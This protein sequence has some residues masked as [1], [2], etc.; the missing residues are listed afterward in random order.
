ME[1]SKIAIQNG[2]LSLSAE[3]SEAL[4]RDALQF[5]EKFLG[6]SAPSTASTPIKQPD[7][8]DI[9]VQKPSD[10]AN[11][12]SK[13]ENVFDT[14]DDKLKII[15]HVPGKTK[16]EQSRNVALVVL[17]GQLLLGVEQ[18]PS[19]TIRQ[20][21]VDQGCYDST[22]FAQYLKGLKS[23]VVM[24]TKTGGGYDVKLTAPGRKDAKELIE[25]LNGEG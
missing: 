12:P 1:S 6:G 5:W 19:D 22:N 15:A 2:P 20:A 8:I 11:G 4:V 25:L 16:A 18:V 10:T 21:C 24:N 23:R 3:G 14:V 9:V 7:P 13:F 17:Y